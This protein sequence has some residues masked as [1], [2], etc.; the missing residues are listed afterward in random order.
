MTAPLIIGSTH[1]DPGSD[2][3]LVLGPSLGTTATRLWGPCISLLA[4]THRILSWDLPGH[5]A[6]PNVP[7]EPMTMADLAEGVLNL[8][9]TTFGSSATF[10]YAGDS[11]GGAVG[12]QLMLDHSERVST[13][14]VM[15]TGAKIGEHRTWLERAST[16]RETGTQTLADA[17]KTRWFSPTYGESHPTEV[18][19]MLRDLADVEDEGYA[20]VCESL[21]EFDVHARLAEIAVPVVA[22]AGSADIVTPPQSLRDMAGGI[23]DSHLRVLDGVGHL[24]PLEAPAV[25]SEAIRDATDQ[26]SPTDQAR[27]SS[28]SRLES[29]GRREPLARELSTHDDR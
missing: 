16:V 14:V 22:L 9:N 24:A 29:V 18:A 20:R 19:A 13:A 27:D 8:V 6:N 10:A 4:K 25:V 15:C 3:L 11:V 2:G 21:A 1:G 12:L 28:E 7:D 23:R 26:V 5:G 17:S